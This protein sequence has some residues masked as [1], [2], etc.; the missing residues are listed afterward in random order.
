MVM[1]RV[2]ALTVVALAVML[3]LSAPPAAAQAN[4][5][6]P[7]G[8]GFTVENANEC[9]PNTEATATFV[10]GDGD[11]TIAGVA[12]TDPN[13]HFK[14]RAE[15]P[16]STPLGAGTITVACGLEGSLLT[17][18]V[19]VVEPTELELTEYIPH[20]AA[21]LGAIV[22]CWVSGHGSDAARPRPRLAALSQCRR[23]RRQ[24]PSRSRIMTTIPSIGSGTTKLS[25]G[26]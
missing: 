15:V 23:R 10:D 24:S 8:K 16:A 20:A 21:G 17:Y 14:I 26:P 3:A 9:V 18:D 11:E 25:A 22:L 6:V 12:I 13:G 2:R 7:R 1:M 19:A 4:I 5:E